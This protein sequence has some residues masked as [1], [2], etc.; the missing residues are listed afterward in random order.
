MNANLAV[1]AY[2]TCGYLIVVYAW[3]RPDVPLRKLGLVLLV[4]LALGG[5]LFA[6]ATSLSRQQDLLKPLPML[7]SDA[8]SSSSDSGRRREMPVSA[9]R[10]SVMYSG[11]AGIVRRTVRA[12][13]LGNRSAAG[14][15]VIELLATPPAFPGS[16]G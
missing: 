7:R 10:Q 15:A 12:S 3:G 16:R 1:L 4:F 8:A 9:R 5:P 14:P 6:R 11:R 2:A 13:S